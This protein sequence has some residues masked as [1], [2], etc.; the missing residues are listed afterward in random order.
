MRA[1]ILRIESNDND[2]FTNC[3]NSTKSLASKFL[4]LLFELNSD[5]LTHKE[6]QWRNALRLDVLML[7][8]RAGCGSDAVLVSVRVVFKFKVWS[9]PIWMVLMVFSANLFD[10]CWTCSAQS[11]H[12]EASN[13]SCVRSNPNLK[14]QPRRKYLKFKIPLFPFK[15]SSE[16]ASL[17]PLP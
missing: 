4:L 14:I 3:G 5:A 6:E 9:D 10:C 16:A 13:D 1:E 7:A 11:S 17:D 12:S 8:Q 15:F 2:Q